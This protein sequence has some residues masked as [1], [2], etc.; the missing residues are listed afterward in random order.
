MLF[1]T[2]AAAPA[3]PNQIPVPGGRLDVTIV[4]HS[5]EPPDAVLLSWVEKAGRAV[6]AYYGSF[7]V[8][9]V[10]VTIH[11]GGSGSISGGETRGE[12]GQASIRISVGEDTTAEDFAANW[13]LVHEMVHLALPSM[14][15]H[16]WLEEGIA[17]YVEPLV[18]ARAGL[19]PADDIWKWLLW[20]APKGLD[21]IR[22]QGLD[23]SHGWNATYW[24]GAVYCFLA[25]VEIRQRTNNRKSLDDAL[26]GIVKAGGDVRISW[27]IERALKAG[28]QATGVPVLEE[29]YTKMSNAPVDADLPGLF[30]RLGVSGN[31]NGVTYDDPAPLAAIRKGI[32][33]GPAA[34]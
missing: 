20:G 8:Q 2:L 9:R 14:T 21:G 27:P 24:G 11:A 33:T 29:L 7:P 22:N 3:S 32:T 28:D 4:R 23:R 18:R 19:A 25:D 1:F 17:T 30:R 13:E 6:A 15:G 34:R 5:V 12:G 16:A 10:A 26:R 31:K